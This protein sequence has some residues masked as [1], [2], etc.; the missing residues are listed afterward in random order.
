[1]AL[2]MDFTDECGVYHP[3]A[4]WRMTHLNVATPE[5]C[6]RLHFFAYKDLQAFGAGKQ[7]LPGGR[8]E[9]VVLG[10]DFYAVAMAP[11]DGA[12]LY[13]V[14]ANAAEVYALACKDTPSGQVG[15][16]GQ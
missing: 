14:L 4:H 12:S 8:K 11:P 13:A 1:M 10:N 2:I 16:D 6:I 3:Q 7:P 9:Y 15:T 5:G